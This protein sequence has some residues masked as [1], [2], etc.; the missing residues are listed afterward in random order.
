MTNNVGFASPPTILVVDDSLTVRRILTVYL[1]PMRAT[2]VEARGAREAMAMLAGA[3]VDLMIADVSM[4]E[5]D[6]LALVKA[7]RAH[8][9]ARLRRLPVVLLTGSDVNR[10]AGLDAGAN[11]FLN[12]PVSP[13]E[14]FRVIGPLLG[15]ASPVAAVAAKVS[16]P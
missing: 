16:M 5:V 4:P 10:A 11:A 8:V 14:L 2:V 9:D 1:A 15:Q 13:S 6:G 7:L 3:A 12:K